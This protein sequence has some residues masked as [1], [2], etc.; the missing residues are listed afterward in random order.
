MSF[1]VIEVLVFFSVPRKYC[2]KFTAGNKQA[3]ASLSWALS[4][5]GLHFSFALTSLLSSSLMSFVSFIRLPF[6]PPFHYHPRS[7]DNQALDKEI[8]YE[9]LYET[10]LS[11]ED[12]NRKAVRDY[13]LERASLATVFTFYLFCVLTL[14]YLFKYIC[15]YSAN[16]SNHGFQPYIQNVYYT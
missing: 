2:L 16:L 11:R 4:C 6:P 5:L 8:E 15:G 14:V 3:C 1:C 13:L 7:G 10:N 12:Q 9:P